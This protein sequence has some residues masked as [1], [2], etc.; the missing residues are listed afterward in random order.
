MA[1]T[2]EGLSKSVMETVR[3][4]KPKKDRQQLLFPEFGYTCMTRSGPQNSW[5]PLLK[6]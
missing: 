1:L 2:K 3:L 6:S 5:T 4:K